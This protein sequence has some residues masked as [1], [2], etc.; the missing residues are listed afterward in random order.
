MQCFIPPDKWYIKFHQRTMINKNKVV[1]VCDIIMLGCIY[2][3]AF[4]MPISKAIIEISSTLA[5]VT[6]V[7]KKMLQKKI[8]PKTYLNPAIITYLFICGFSI[9]IS[10]SFRISLE[11]FIFKTIQ[12]LLLYFVIVETITSKKRLLV[13]LSILII[14]ATLVGFDGIYQYLNA[15]HIDFLRHRSSAQFHPRIT[16]SFDMPNGLGAYLGPIII[17]ALSLSFINFRKRILTVS[18]IISAVLL[19]LALA[20]SRARGAWFGFTAAMLYAAFSTEGKKRTTILVLFLV[21]LISWMTFPI[22]L[23]NETKNIFLFFTNTAADR[24]LILQTGWNMFISEPMLGQGLGT[25]MDNF[26]KF[27]IKNY[28]YGPSYAHNCFLQMTA[29]TGLIGLIAFLWIVTSYFAKSITV[30]KNTNDPS[31]KIIIAGFTASIF[32]YLANSVFDSN[33]YVL[34]LA[35]LFWFLLGLGISTM[36]IASLQEA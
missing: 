34:T 29:E 3:L 27:S 13:V 10:S 15:K 1:S 17:L 30:L 35:T 26:Y 20:M 18:L 16:A 14:S 25:F 32:G 8:L 11:T 5:I 33:L 4:F 24:N 23:K 12:Y 28:P 21:V 9:I 31:N 2:A 6:L 36:R 7:I 19:F 22:I